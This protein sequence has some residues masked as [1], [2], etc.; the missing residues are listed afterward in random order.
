MK[1]TFMCIQDKKF[2]KVRLAR[3]KI[4]NSLCSRVKPHQGTDVNETQ[5]ILEALLPL[6]EKI[7]GIAKANLTDAESRITALSSD[8]IATISWWP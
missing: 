5:L 7:I 6:K 4:L 3:L 8:I 1:C 2:W